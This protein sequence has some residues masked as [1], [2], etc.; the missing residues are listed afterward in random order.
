MATLL[1]E[2]VLQGYQTKCCELY[3]VIES[4]GKKT[5]DLKGSN[6]LYDIPGRHVVQ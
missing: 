6:T 3:M 2:T 1:C 5:P 4:A